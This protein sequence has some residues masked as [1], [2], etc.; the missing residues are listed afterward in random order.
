MVDGGKEL[1][2]EAELPVKLDVSHSHGAARKECGPDGQ[3][4]EG[5][6]KS[7]GQLNQPAEP[8]LGTDRWLM[9][10]QDPENLLKAVEGEHDAGQDAQN[11]INGV[12]FGTEKTCE[13][14]VGPFVMVQP[15]LRLA[16]FARRLTQVEPASVIFIRR[17]ASRSY[18]RPLGSLC[19]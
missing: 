12:G 17:G 15:T 4:P 2:T 7:G 11:R 18:I 14:D 5:D 10:G 19:G 8:E 6:S 3:H 1:L 9:I 13:H 16:D